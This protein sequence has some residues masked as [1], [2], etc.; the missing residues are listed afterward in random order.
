MS[1]FLR[2][3]FL[4]IALGITSVCAEKIELN[5]D[6]KKSL[7]V[8]VSTNGLTRLS[9]KGDR[10]REVIGLDETVTV[11]KDEAN[12]HLFLKGINSKQTI[13][14]V[15]EGGD[16]QDLTL[17]PG[18]KGS[19]T[20][21][22][23]SEVESKKSETDFTPF[24]LENPFQSMLNPT[25]MTHPQDMMISLIKQLFVGIGKSVETSN[26]RISKTGMEAVCLRQIQ[27]QNMIGEVFSV[28]N[29]ESNTT[30]LLEKD[31][32]QSGDIAIALGKKQ[33][34]AGAS[35][36]LFVIRTI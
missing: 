34:N 4:S 11:E 21:V 15:T 35:T 14:V 6:D 28:T 19:T 12:G 3:K 17:V 36:M 18:A 16:L 32:Y 5:Y 22:L 10:L 30:I 29:K 9:V 25:S 26:Q 8:N 23:K 33:L 31:F 7:I 1:L 27:S 13:T 24:P 2:Y 20:I